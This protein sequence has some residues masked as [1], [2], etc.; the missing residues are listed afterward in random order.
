MQVSIKGLKKLFIFLTG[1]F[2]K[3]SSITVQESVKYNGKCSLG[4]FKTSGQLGSHKPI[5]LS[6]LF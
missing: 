2:K 1:L 3:Q 5:Q 4:S 6:C